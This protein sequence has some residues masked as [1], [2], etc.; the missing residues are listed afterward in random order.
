MRDGPAFRGCVFGA[1]NEADPIDRRSEISD[2]R[3]SIRGAREAEMS[4][5]IFP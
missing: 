3:G 4:E 5:E 1:G 2:E